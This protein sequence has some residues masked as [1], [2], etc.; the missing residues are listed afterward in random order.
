MD[1]PEFVAIWGALLIVSV[2]GFKWGLTERAAS[3]FFDQSLGG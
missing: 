1:V 2:V 3:D